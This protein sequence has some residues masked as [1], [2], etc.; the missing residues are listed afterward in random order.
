MSSFT[1]QSNFMVG[2]GQLAR[3]G[4]DFLAADLL[5]TFFSDRERGS[6]RLR[7]LV[8]RIDFNEGVGELRAFLLDTEL[9]TM[10]GTRRV[11]LAENNLRLRLAPRPK[12]PTLLSLA[13]DY[14][15]RGPLQNP[16]I[17]PDADDIIRGVATTLGSFALT[18]GA[19]ALLPLIGHQEE[20]MAN[21]CIVALTGEA[22]AE[23]AAQ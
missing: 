18:G 14:T 5:Q 3:G 6:T 7:C 9:I 20:H 4:V 12:D 15:V 16:R 19:A 17:R 21:P 1:G 10:T 8:N 13:A 2:R 23:G 22:P 11:N